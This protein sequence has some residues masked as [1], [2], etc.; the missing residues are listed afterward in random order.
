MG[1]DLV[2]AGFVCRIL[3]FELNIVFF[4]IRNIVAVLDLYDLI[5]R[6]LLRLA[7]FLQ[8][9]EGRCLRLELDGRISAFTA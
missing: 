6:C 4:G 3:E 7:P 5:I 9:D 2:K 8:I 1:N